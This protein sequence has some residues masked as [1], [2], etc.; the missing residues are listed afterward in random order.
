[1]SDDFA[2]K[3]IY[4]RGERNLTQQEL[5]DASGVSP[6]QISRYEAGQAKPRKT[7]L[8][9]LAEAL[10]VPVEELQDEV[11]VVL[12]SPDG[13]KMPITID[14]ETFDQMQKAA[15]A[16]GKSLGEVLSETLA[17]GLRMLKESPEFAASL[18]RQIEESRK[19]D[20]DE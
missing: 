6:S 10:C 5:G 14:R 8:R 1:M 20:K 13:D 19:A 16:S 7:V 18:K 17:W 15:R 3:L 4:L 11:P 2:T 9:K 12:E